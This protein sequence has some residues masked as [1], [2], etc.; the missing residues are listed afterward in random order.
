MKDCVIIGKPNVGKTLFLVNFA[1]YIGACD[2]QFAQAASDEARRYEFG[3]ARAELVGVSPHMT[4]D[5]RPATLKIR[6][7]KGMREFY[8]TDS[9]GLCE[10]IHA[11]PSV[12]A[13]MAASL[14]RLRAA[15]IILHMVDASKASAPQALEAAG[16]VD[17]EIARFSCWKWGYA[18]LAN[19]MDLPEAERGL[20]RIKS[21]FPSS[22]I[23][24][25][26]ALTGRGF[27]QVKGFIMRHI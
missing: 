23:I 20:Q 1:E 2:L 14:R 16:E 17:L 5:V 9:T 18:L 4:R 3:R 6:V 12:R 24:P 19:K 21:M 8:M 26:S 11:D 27:R 7:G 25:V 22:L 13:G 15:D 10:G